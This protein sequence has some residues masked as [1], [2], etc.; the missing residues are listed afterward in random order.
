MATVTR[1]SARRLFVTTLGRFVAATASSCLHPPTHLCYKSTDSLLQR[2]LDHLPPPQ[3]LS[4]CL[5]SRP[6]SVS[7]WP[8]YGRRGLLGRWAEE[9]DTAAAAVRSLKA[10]PRRPR[11]GVALDIDGVLLKGRHPMP[12][13]ERAL[14]RLVRLTAEASS[15]ERHVPFVFLTN[16]GGVTERMKAMELSKIFGLQF[17]E[18]QVIL[19]HTPFRDLLLERFCDKKVLVLGKHQPKLVMKEYGFQHVMTIDELVERYPDIDPLYSLFCREARPGGVGV[20]RNDGSKC[21]L[22]PAESASVEDQHRHISSVFVVSDPTNWGRDIQ[23]ICDV[24]QSGGLPGGTPASAVA[25]DSNS[26]SALAVPIMPPPTQ[27]P[28]YFAADDFV[29]QAK[30]PAPRFGMGAFR[31]ALQTIYERLAGKRLEYTSFGKPY[32]PAFRAAER[33]MFLVVTVRR[34]I[35]KT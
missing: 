26:I 4:F 10:T 28:L 25:G 20:P 32:P 2:L 12:G 13:A 6:Y 23:V 33:S 24:L 31:I 15:G 19:G 17:N 27:L 8:N 22:H 30:F 29:Y 9:E 14:R 5:Y 18:E 16:G 21:T 34:D 11:F 1:S 35:H 7:L 3:C